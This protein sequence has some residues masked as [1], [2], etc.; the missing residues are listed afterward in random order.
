MTSSPVTL[1]FFIHREKKMTTLTPHERCWVF[2]RAYMIRMIPKQGSNVEFSWS[3]SSISNSSPQLDTNVGR[4]LE[5]MVI[6]NLDLNLSSSTYEWNG[7]LK[8]LFFSSFCFISLTC[9][10]GDLYIHIYI[11]LKNYFMTATLIHNGF[12]A[13]FK[14]VYKEV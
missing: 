5:F 4:Q 2:R 9:K 12:K 14:N 1:I 11:H 7:L 3:F 13:V 6:K 8:L 10:L